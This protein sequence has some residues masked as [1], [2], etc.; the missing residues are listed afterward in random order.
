MKPLYL[1][2][3]S[4]HTKAPEIGKTL[5]LTIRNQTIRT[6][7][8]INLKLLGNDVF[9]VETEDSVYLV[10][11][12]VGASYETP[13]IGHSFLLQLKN[14]WAK[15]PPVKSIKLC[16]HNNDLFTITRL[17]TFYSTYIVCLYNEND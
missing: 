2:T 9:F 8:V 11:D 10:G 6:K 13:H 17:E 16:Y 12:K 14:G 15:I 5:I 3:L 7:E 1:A 4:N